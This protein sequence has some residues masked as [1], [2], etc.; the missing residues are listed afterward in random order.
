MWR[1]AVERL[2]GIGVS[3]GVVLGRAVVLTQRTEVM[4]F[5]IPPERVEQEVAAL[6]RSQA[7][8]RQQLQDIK[9]R[10]EHGPGSELAALF[11]AQLLMLDDPM[12]VGR[13]ES[14]VRA[15]R[16]NAAWAV[17]RAYEELYHVFRSMEDPYLRERETDV[18]DVAGRLR[19][20]LRHGAKGPKEL[21]SEVDGPSVLIADELTASVAAQLDWS[22]VQAFATDAGSRTYHTAI[23]ARSLKV[24]AIVGLHDASL[25][26]AAGTPVVL[27]GTTGEL[28]VAPTPAQIDEAHRRA[29][30]PRRR[31]AATT[32]AGPV[33]TT[34]GMRIRLEANIELLE[35]LPF[36]NEHGAEGVGLYRS[37][38][39]LSGRP[40]ESVTEDDQYAL[41][42]S[43]IEQVAPR[44][45]TIRTFDVDERHFAG[46][47]RGPERRRT[48]PGLRGLRLGLANPA[49]LRT[50]L[51]ALVRASAHGPL[52]IMFP[53]VTAVEEVR[54]ARKMLAEVVSGFSGIDPTQL[55]VG[56]MIEVPSAALAADLL[57]PEV[58]FFTIG[59]N[60]LI[61]F[62][63]AVDRTDDRVSDLYEPLHPAVLR[64]IRIVRRAATR[65]HIP[66]SL[67]GEMASDPA[68]VGLLVGL[69]LTEFS[70]TPGAI[71]IIR[72]VVEE[73]S[74]T[75]ARRLASHALRLATAAEIEQYLF[76]AL[77]ASPFQ[78]SPFR[79]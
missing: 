55:K 32:A 14:I 45:V 25:R 71:P 41:Y 5:P 73:L 50:Q 23:L 56:A 37:E 63:L 10:V 6:L 7:A 79:E 52:R 15:E 68:L 34:D 51:R 4:R 17:H 16:V 21:L 20:N 49:V 22:R 47:G 35:D 9:A 57:A 67:C 3:P 43:L 38:F 12:L 26:I 66:V 40:I 70:M 61:Q 31:R 29:T 53:F 54:D 36:L 75:E 28:T 74:A 59:T 65:H 60:D 2:T 69:G 27:D 19:L 30:P 72:H 62:C 8:S 46:P 18:A 1:R 13:A 76:D 11:D 77:A 42:R 48:R 58:D 44:P 39:M 64:L 78:R 24:P 33:S